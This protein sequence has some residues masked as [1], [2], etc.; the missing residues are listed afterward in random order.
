MK[1]EELLPIIEPVLEQLGIDLVDLYIHGS[2]Q[3][4]IVRVLVD[5]VGGIPISRV[6]KAS[7]AIS[8]ILDQKDT[9][10]TRYVLEVS[11]PGADRPLKT[12]RDFFRHNGRKVELQYL[13][14]DE[15]VEKMQGVILQAG[16]GVI[17]IQTET[18]NRILELGRIKSA[19]IIFEF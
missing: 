13:I 16:N 18:A 7:R 3:R 4:T 19:V 11:S 10:Q 8:D 9:F 6:T 2:G 15:T 12:E 14:E 17:Q 5:E 1:A